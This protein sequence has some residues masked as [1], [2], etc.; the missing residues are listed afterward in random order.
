MIQKSIAGSSPIRFVS[1]HTD[2]LLILAHH[3]HHRTTDLP[4]TSQLFV[5]TY[6]ANPTVIRV[7]DVVREH[8]AVIP[9]IFAASA[10]VGYNSV[11][12]VAGI[13]KATVFR[14]LLSLS[15]TFK[16]G[17]QSPSEE[18]ITDSCIEFMLYN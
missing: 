15:H 4:S 17:D 18:E 1:D 6:S 14:T 2:V 12:P 5:E 7:N 8:A 10:L 13:G 11:S 3:L 16:L 9:N